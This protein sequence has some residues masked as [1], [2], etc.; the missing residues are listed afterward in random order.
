M[1]AKQGKIQ[2][3]PA[4]ASGRPETGAMQFGNDWPGVFIRGDNAL[5][6]ARTLTAAMALYPD[7]AMERSILRGLRDTLLSCS[8]GNTGWPPS[9]EIASVNTTE[10]DK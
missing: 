5:F 4:L 3:V 7:K 8:V 1:S 2:Q 10:K 9:T 6:F